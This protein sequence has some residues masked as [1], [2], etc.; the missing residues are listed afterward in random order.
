M[1]RAWQEEVRDTIHFERSTLL[2]SGT[3]ALASAHFRTNQGNNEDWQ[4]TS[5]QLED[6]LDEW[7]ASNRFS[8]LVSGMDLN[9]TL[10]NN[11][12]ASTGNITLK[13]PV[14]H[15]HQLQEITKF[16]AK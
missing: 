5:H 6:H 3:L 13:Q 10:P 12:D 15:K 4:V 9:F 11:L 16:I 8:M 2:L 14:A 1:P 7:N